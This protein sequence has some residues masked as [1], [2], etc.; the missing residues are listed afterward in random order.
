MGAERGDSCNTCGRSTWTGCYVLTW[1]F[2]LVGVVV[3]HIAVSNLIDPIKELPANVRIGFYQEL[4]FDHLVDDSQAVKEQ[5]LKALQMCGASAG[6]CQDGNLPEQP[7]PQTNDTS[8]PKT[9]IL[10]AFNRSLRTIEK[11]ATDK[12]L[13]TAELQSTADNLR[14]ITEQL[15][16]LDTD[17]CRA[18]NE[19][20]CSIYLAAEGLVTGAQQALDEVDSIINSKE[21]QDFEDNSDRLVYLHG[22]PYLLLVSMLF[23]FCFWRKDAAC[24]CCGGSFVGCLLMVAHMI[25]WLVA[26][27]ISAVIVGAG[28]GYGKVPMEKLEG[29]PTV[30]EVIDHIEANFEGFWKIVIVPLESPLSQ[31]FTANLIFLLVCILISIY[32]L[33]T[34]ICRPY[35]DKE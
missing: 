31:F 16:N 12:Y 34:C 21:I 15:D 14:D 25:L 8:A 17:Q 28:L 5:S 29:D 18:T 23:F 6:Q 24:C 10:G 4:R 2:W 3:C 22:L 11:V 33:C 30:E 20:Y 7:V 9:A 32:G 1:A 13:G 26:L 27:I 35:A 19:A